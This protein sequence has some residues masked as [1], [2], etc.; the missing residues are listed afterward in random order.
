[1][2]LTMGL[3]F[4]GH[5]IGGAIGAFLGGYF[6]DLFGDYELLWMLS[7]GLSAAAAIFSILIVET[8]GR[9][10]AIP[11]ATVPA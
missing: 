3:V 5:S 4:A 6:Y 11:S 9:A 1:M 8:R 2:G 7:A 10:G